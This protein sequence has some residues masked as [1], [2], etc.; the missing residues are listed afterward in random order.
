MPEDDD[1]EYEN[2]ELRMVDFPD[3][4]LIEGKYT[5]VIVRIVRENNHLVVYARFAELEE[6]E[7]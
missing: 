1:L 6:N 2:A 5:L 7:S 3:T 4:S